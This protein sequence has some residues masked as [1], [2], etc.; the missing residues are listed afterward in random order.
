[1]IKIIDRYISQELLEPFLFGLT[2]FTLILSASMVLFELVRAVIIAG[3]PIVLAIQLFV[4]K[5]PGIVVYIFPMA[6]LL[7]VLLCFARLS[8]DSEI[9]AFRAS[10]ISLVR[11]VAP[12]LV[13]GFIISLVTIL[14]YEIVVPYSNRAAKELTVQTRI[15]KTP[16]MRNNVFV[17]EIENGALKRIFYVRKIQNDV[18]EGVIVQEFVDGALSQI[19]NAKSAKWANNKW[20]FKDG[21][22]YLLSETGEYK[23]LIKFD[24]QEIAIKYNPADF[25]VEDKRPEEMNYHDLKK[26][27]NLKKKMGV[28]IVDLAIQLNSKI[29]IPF[30]S[31]V[32]AL[33]GAS[34]GFNPT[35]RSSSIGLGL[36]I[37]VIFFYYILMFMSMAAGETELISP[38]WA[39]WFP[40]VVT[41]G[42]GIYVLY[43]ASQ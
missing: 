30:A 35:R 17:P 38:F 29:S 36:S 31:F 16:Q 26:Y 37:I 13:W 39:A 18:M 6:T 3:M 42:F 32:F 28:N 21:I 24:E 20:T 25:Y 11:I 34:L 10:G 2:S 12:V 27:I 22:I 23:H 41:A 14:F 7:G 8:G 40:N 9:I 15:E 43:K 33:L 4:Y 5:L 1:M 19:I